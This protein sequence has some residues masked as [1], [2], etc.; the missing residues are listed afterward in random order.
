MPEVAGT[1]DRLGR[2]L[3]HLVLVTVRRTRRTRFIVIAERCH[4]IV[5]LFGAE[6]EQIEVETL[7]I[8]FVEQPGQ[9]F[10]V[11]ARR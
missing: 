11:P 10:V 4:Q 1:R 6:A 5:E 9:Q 7:A 2:R 3:G 8:E